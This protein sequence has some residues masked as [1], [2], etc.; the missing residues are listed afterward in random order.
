[1]S[2]EII[3]T[4]MSQAFWYEFTGAVCLKRV[5]C[6]EGNKIDCEQNKIEIRAA[7]DVAFGG[8]YPLPF[9]SWMDWLLD[10]GLRL[11]KSKKP[12]LIV[13]SG[14]PGSGKTTFAL[15]L[16]YRLASAKYSS[17]EPITLP[18]GGIQKSFLPLYLS[19]DTEAADLADNARRLGWKDF[20]SITIKKTDDINSHKIKI[21]LAK[22]QNSIAPVML[23]G[24]SELPEFLHKPAIDAKFSIG[25]FFG[26]G[27][28]E[29]TIDLSETLKKFLL[30][31][32]RKT[33]CPDIVVLDSLNI[34]NDSHGRDADFMGLYK[35]LV[36]SPSSGNEDTPKIMVVVADST[37]EDVESKHMAYLAD[38]V[39]RL[40][41]DSQHDYFTRYIEIEKTRFQSHILGRHYFKILTA[42]GT[43]R[44]DEST[45][46]STCSQQT[47]GTTDAEGV[48]NENIRLQ[49]SHPYRLQGGL[50]VCPSIHSF[51]SAYRKKSAPPPTGDIPVFLPKMRDL[52]VFPEG[53]CTTFIGD[54]GA[55]KSHFAYTQLLAYLD[56]KNLVNDGGSQETAAIIVSLRED[57]KKTRQTLTKILGQI[58]KGRN[59][60]DYVNSNRLLILHYLP[61]YI[62]PNEFIHRLFLAVHQLRN[63][64][65]KRKLILVFN[66]LDQI[67]PRLPLCTE[68]EMFVPAIVE[69]L[70][71]ESVTS[72]FITGEDPSERSKQY[73]ILPM[74]DLIVSFFKYFVPM[75]T[76][77]ALRKSQGR[78]REEKTLLRVEKIAGGVNAGAKGVLNLNEES[79]LTFEQ[80]E[81]IP[82]NWQRV[83]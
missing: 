53:R 81:G 3:K 27:S 48:C 52:L 36:T 60:D 26:L 30:A 19:G 49:R 32:G 66:S 44:A 73:G 13:I 14:P 37:Y 50:F 76:P 17:G 5:G 57:D 1:M 58:D 21:E 63:P 24:R 83:Y 40:A 10:G 51:L 33:L 55:H 31:Q 4:A 12:L 62:T 39:I 29:A 38:V 25:A 22:E 80:M 18:N 2:N 47:Q 43:D 28:V 54:R 46:M 56:N 72:I 35:Q 68:E 16:C 70:L 82:E 67:G 65:K 20:F 8:E 7:K 61:G 75:R 42:M 59:L 15:E 23:W 64:S 77:H 69:F 9:L 34:I 6:A 79:G 71:A 41:Y 11:P 45:K 78:Y 74:S